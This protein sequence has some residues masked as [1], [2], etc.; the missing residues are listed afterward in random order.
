MRR[1][2]DDKVIGWIHESLDA[3]VR[4]AIQSDVYNCFLVWIKTGKN[5]FKLDEH[6]ENYEKHRA[7]VQDF[8]ISILG[9][10]E[11]NE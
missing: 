11:N 6:L 5:V 3:Y 8:L 7:H 1:Q 2:L 4:K 9:K 10:D